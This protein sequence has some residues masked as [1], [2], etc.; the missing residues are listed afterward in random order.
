[1]PATN[2]RVTSVV[3]EELLEWLR[4]KAERQGIA[5]SLLIR[6]LLLRLREEDEERYWAAAGAERLESFDRDAARSHED[7]WR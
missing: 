2:P 6:D 5:V 3:D 7:A 4:A 1:M